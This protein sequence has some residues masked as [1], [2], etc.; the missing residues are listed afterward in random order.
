MPDTAH[1]LVWKVRLNQGPRS[2]E[3]KANVRQDLLLM[4]AQMQET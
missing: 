3:E 4:A 2:S 1:M